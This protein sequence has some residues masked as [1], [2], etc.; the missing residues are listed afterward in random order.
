MPLFKFRFDVTQKTEQFHEFTADTE[1]V[2][3][4]QALSM[5]NRENKTLTGDVGV[6]L[7]NLGN[8]WGRTHNC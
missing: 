1:E 4:Q 6:E 2:A 7:V 3:I 5:F 8:E